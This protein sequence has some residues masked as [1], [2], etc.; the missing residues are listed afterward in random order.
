MTNNKCIGGYFE[1]E[2]KSGKEYYQNLIRLNTG[3]AAFEYILRAKDYRK[4]YLPY[5]TCEVMLEP[6]N[7]LKLDV[8][9]YHIDSDFKPFMDLSLIGDDEVMVFT[10]YF[11]ICDQQVRVIA[12][13]PI[14]LIIDNS[15]AF[16]SKQI[17]GCDTFYS[18]R[19]FFG[20]PDGAYLS[21][22]VKLNIQLEREDSF[23][24]IKH[25]IERIE[26]GA[27]YAY[28]IFKENNAS[29]TNSPIKLMSRGTQRILESIN[30]DEVIDQR[31]ENFQY[32][33]SNLKRSNKLK[34]MLEQQEV[35]MIYPYYTE[36]DGLKGKLISNKIFVATY[37]P[38]I[39]Q[40]T[41]PDSVEF[42]NAK[43]II[44]L[45]IDQRYSTIDMKEILRVIE[46][47]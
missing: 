30:Y 41:M 15:Q 40:W 47:N 7:K 14:N 43:N 12:T 17:D 25:L 21:T 20:V 45:P 3:R 35:P 22:D 11:G 1:L 34:L 37:W 28:T 33:H 24:R 13:S 19:K 29:F 39:Y 4:V 42:L 27:E 16:F 31:I 18:A 5:Y 46:A 9:F 32:L 2:L 36:D 38:N 26:K 6:V 8:E 23:L 44:A 10:N